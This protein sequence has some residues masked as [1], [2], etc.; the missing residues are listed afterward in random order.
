[1][2]VIPFDPEGAAGSEKGEPLTFWQRIV[3][4][5]D[6]CVVNRTYRGIPT[7]AL[8]RSKYEL[9]RCRRVLHGDATPA[10]VVIDAARSRRAARAVQT[11]T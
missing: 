5:L 3:Q 9:N 10:V 11:R 6:R 7:T 4:L 2:R 8:R 1:M